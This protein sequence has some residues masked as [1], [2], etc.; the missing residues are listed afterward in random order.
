[1]KR[2]R[3]ALETVLRVRRVQEEAAGF[4][5]AHANRDLQR[6]VLDHRVALASYESLQL[7]HGQQDLDTFRRDRDKAERFAGAVESA[8]TAVQVAADEVAT[9]HGAWSV[10]AQRV[11]ALERLDERRRAE[12]LRRRAAG[13]DGRHRRVGDR[14][15]VGRRRR[16]PCAA[17]RRRGSAD[18]TSIDTSVMVARM[19]A[20][21]AAV[22]SL[23]PA[24]EAAA[25]SG[26]FQAVLDNANAALTAAA[27]PAVPDSSGA[28]ARSWVA[29]SVDNDPRAQR[30]DRHDRCAPGAGV[31]GSSVVADA[32]QYLGV[33]YRWGGT[34]PSTGLDCSGLVQRVYGDLGISLPRTS[35]EQ[36]TVGTPVASLAQ[37]QPGDLVFFEPTSSGPGH[38]GIYIGNGQMIDAPHTGTDVQVQAVGQPIAIRR[39]LPAATGD[40]LVG[41]G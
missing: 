15:M 9:R 40:G 8:W 26:E 5:L 13:R 7:G 14:G 35:Q 29:R 34:D 3:F 1:M 36:V 16:R 10:A 22:S 24:L 32:Q 41:A 12:W 11:A 21:G 33:P 19:Q 38:V 6:A 25:P 20:L 23:G 37:A 30:R 18:V 39:V 4:A 28:A 2:Y 17:A 31:S 27:D